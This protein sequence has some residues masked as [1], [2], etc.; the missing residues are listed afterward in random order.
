MK[1]PFFSVIIPTLNEEND[2]SNL[3]NSLDKQTFKN[4]EVIIVDNGSEDKTIPDIKNLKSNVEFPIEIVHCKEKGISYARNFGVKYAKGKY[5]IF[6]DADGVVTKKWLEIAHKQ[7]SKKDT[8]KAVT[9][10]YFHYPTS[11]IIKLFTYN[12]LYHIGYI[13]YMFFNRTFLRKSVL[14]G[15][16]FAIEKKAFVKTGMF[17]HK[18]HEDIFYTKER[19]LKHFTV[20]N[21]LFC[22]RMILLNS[23][24]RLEAKGIFQTYLEW[25]KEYRDEKPTKDYEPY[26]KP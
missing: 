14:T 7:L 6:F 2:I 24:R 4:F 13:P 5:L 20:K 10:I 18:V 23:P 21:M 22:P 26:H 17:P 25:F 16:N 11:N 9:G 19:F 3:L 1:K 12:F 15:N 8:I